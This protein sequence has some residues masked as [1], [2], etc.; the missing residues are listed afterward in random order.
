MEKREKVFDSEGD[1]LITH[2][3]LSGP[4]VLDVSRSIRSGDVIKLNFVGMD[5]SSF[6]QKVLDES[7]ENPSRRLSAFL[8]E[9]QMT[10]RLREK[11][12]ELASLSLENRMGELGKKRVTILVETFAA[13]SCAVSSVGGFDVAMA[14][15]GGVSLKEISPKTME[16]RIVKGLFLPEKLWMWMAIVGATIFKR[17]FPWGTWREATFR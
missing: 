4:G 7:K 8:K 6:R 14:T 9:F 11:L 5:E 15:A 17:P 16:S 3:G 10:K 1:I 12:L 13:F 2:K